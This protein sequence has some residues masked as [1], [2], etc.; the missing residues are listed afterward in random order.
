MKRRY[1][2]APMALMVA[3]SALAAAADPVVALAALPVDTVLRVQLNDTI[4]SDRSR[5]G[6]RFSA[7]VE[8]PTLPDGTL[9]RGVVTRVQPAVSGVPGK[10]AFDF[11][12]LELPSGQMIPIEATPIGLD[13]RSVRTT[14]SGRMVAT[15]HGKT[16]TGAYAGYGAAGGLAIGSL[17]GKNVVGGLLGAGAG[18]LLGKHHAK[19]DER[20][21]VVLND[22][23]EMGVRL[24]EPITVAGR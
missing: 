3:A 14:P 13:S 18:Y 1:A 22:G 8:D 2:W 9:I 10:I 4:G 7:T 24:D 6:D 11:R 21:N 12:S 19:K 15:S 17:I 20:R 5:P 23:A 16:N